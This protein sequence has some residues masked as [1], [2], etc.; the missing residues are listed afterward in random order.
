MFVVTVAKYKVKIHTLIIE[1]ILFF[2]G[3]EKLIDR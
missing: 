1:V 2:T 3:P